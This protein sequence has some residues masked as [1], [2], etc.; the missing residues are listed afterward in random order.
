MRLITK[1]TEVPNHTPST[2]TLPEAIGG[3]ILAAM[4]VLPAAWIGG[5]SLPVDAAPRT[6]RS[7]SGGNIGSSGGPLDPVRDRRSGLGVSPQIASEAGRSD[8]PRMARPASGHLRFRDDPP[9]TRSADRITAPSRS[10]VRVLRRALRLPGW[11]IRCRNQRARHTGRY[12]RVGFVERI[13]R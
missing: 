13:L 7:T 5:R 6:K 3:T 11:F 10:R 1:R 2:R 4:I 12:A 9:A 8:R